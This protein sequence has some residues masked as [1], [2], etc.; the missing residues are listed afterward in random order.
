MTLF[1]TFQS[2]NYRENEVGR[3][4]NQGRCRNVEMGGN[5]PI[6]GQLW[7]RATLCNRHQTELIQFLIEGINL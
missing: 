3:L 4:R 1:P 7:Q 2:Q 6:D 5:Q